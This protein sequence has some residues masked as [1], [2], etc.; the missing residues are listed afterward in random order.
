VKGLTSAATIW[1]VAGVGMCS[2]LGLFYLALLV[3]IT[4]VFIL[5]IL[6]RVEYGFS[7]FWVKDAEVIVVTKQN[8]AVIKT[9]RL[10]MGRMR[11]N[12]SKLSVK[13]EDGK[14]RITFTAHGGNEILSRLGTVLIRM[15]D[16][17]ETRLE[18]I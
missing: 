1:V 3:S 11:I 2:G 14:F 13:K 10:T 17:E 16:I 4:V 18:E 5:L 12:H 8:P 6:G 15:P 7:E 9:I